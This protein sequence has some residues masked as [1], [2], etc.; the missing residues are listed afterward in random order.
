MDQDQ[1]AKFM[2][3]GKEPV[4][5]GFSKLGIPDPRADLN[6]EKPRM[7]HP[8]PHL[9]DGTVG[10]LQGDR[11]QR[12]KARRVLSGDS[13]EELVLRCCQ[14]RGPRRRGFVTKRHR[15]WRKHLHRNAFTVHVDDPSFG[16]PAPMI[17]GPIGHPAEHQLRLGFIGALDDGPAIVR[18]DP[19]QVGQISVDGV[20]VDID[21]V[22]ADC[23]L[24]VDGWL[25]ATG[26]M[27]GFR[28]P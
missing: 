4:E 8:A 16:R 21:E 14:F 26:A 1:S 18:I 17:D 28:L 12:R 9:V 11:A 20:R 6:T 10:V 3:D 25:P 7:T 5:A 23:R 27:A 19:S 24:S 22:G 15:N 13:C 2:R